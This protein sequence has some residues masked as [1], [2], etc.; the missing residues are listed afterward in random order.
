MGAVIDRRALVR[1]HNVVLQGADVRSP[2]SV[3]NGELCFTAD[4]TG[5]QT[6]PEW[7]R[8]AGRGGE[9][10]GTLLGTQAQWAW[11]STPGG[12]Q[13]QLDEVLVE[14]DTPTGRV[15]YVDMIGTIGGEGE[16]AASETERWLRAN[17]HRLDLGRI[18][19]EFL[20]S[21]GTPVTAG[22][23]DLTG[24]RQELDLWHGLLRSTF[25]V[26]GDVVRVQ[27]VCHPAEDSLG[28][29]IESAA[30]RA[31]RLA[32]RMTFPYGSEQWHDAADWARPAA[33]TTT[34]ERVDGGWRIARHLDTAR[35]D[36]TVTAHPEGTL[37]R[38]GQHE[39]RLS[40]GSDRLD[41]V[42]AFTRAGPTTSDAPAGVP[43]AQGRS[44]SLPPPVDQVAAAAAEH[45]S[46]FWSTGGA[47]ELAGSSDG[48]AHEL[49]RR[50]VLSQYL[51]AINC[52]GSLPPQE[53]GLVCNSWYGRFHL[54][55]H[56][57]HA[58]HFALW[59]RPE[60]LERSMAWYRTAMKAGREMA[61]RQGYAGVRWPKQVGPDARESPSPVGPFLIWQQPHPIYLAEL[62]YRAKP[63]RDILDAYAEIVFE[64]AE[65]MASF[66]AETSRG[67]ELGP[68]LIPAQ[69]SYASMRGRL[70]NPT[71]ELAYWQWGLE[72][73]ARWRDRLGLDRRARWAEVARGLVR[74]HQRAGVYSAIDVEPYTLRTD[75][76][77]M[78]CGLGFLP[79]TRLIDPAVM[80]P[81]LEDVLR[82]WDWASTWG[83][84]Y[85][86][87]A[88]CATR[89]GQPEL[90]LSAL[91]MDVAKNEY[92]PNGHNWQTPSLPLY[93]PGNGGLLAAIAL[94]AAG[95]D[96][97]DGI[98][99]GVHAP[100]FPDDGSWTVRWEGLMPSP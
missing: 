75:H 25:T 57:W 74:P 81:T 76:P 86:V 96:G 99:A 23:A 89:L 78:L 39:L 56:W 2:L 52:S 69:E 82:D 83:W 36:V 8:V 3:G 14:Y 32:V 88:M 5:L 58:A 90:A 9:P 1:R 41:L 20:D 100:G 97:V 64:T 38:L 44:P 31:G 87:I 63:S 92:L 26:N 42:I 15:P 61:E 47:V 72:T 16:R 94:M 11:H 70:S 17:P 91:A 24:V 46:R 43:G 84:D 18:G 30:L 71:F 6:F 65:F 85:P 33:H 93:L 40:T 34:V 67:F 95:W 27:T 98:H 55:M 73:A 79:R 54:E 19:L 22:L 12:D 37:E 4:I 49:E 77:S 50:I 51:T 10:D 45:W 66:A 60:L 28:V 29:R 62:L 68:P 13:H 7:Y 53:T 21:A 80:R 35:Y 59:G 48:R